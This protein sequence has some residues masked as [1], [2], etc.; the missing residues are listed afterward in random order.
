M[1]KTETKTSGLKTE[2]KTETQMLKT[3]IKSSGLKTKTK[4]SHIILSRIPAKLLS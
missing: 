2:I 1:L 3:E 4:T